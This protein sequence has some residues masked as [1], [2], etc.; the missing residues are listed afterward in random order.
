MTAYDVSEWTEF[1]VAGASA[2]LAGLVFVAV[3]INVDSIL[4]FQ[5]YRRGARDGDAAAQRGARLADRTDTR[6]V[7]GRAG[8]R[9]ARRR[10]GVRGADPRAY[11][12][13]HCQSP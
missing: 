9:V 4:R 2:A 6:A 12:P 7:A 5:G 1:F 13:E 10:P 8:G 11:G 3:S